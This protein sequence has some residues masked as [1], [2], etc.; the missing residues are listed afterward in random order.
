M[1]QTSRRE[2]K[3]LIALESP[4]L[5]ASC[6]GSLREHLITATS[7]YAGI[8]TVLTGLAQAF[9]LKAVPALYNERWGSRASGITLIARSIHDVDYHPSTRC[10]VTHV[11]CL[12]RPDEEL[13]RTFGVVN[14][15]PDGLDT[16]AFNED[17]DLP[18]LA[19]ATDP[20][21]VGRELRAEGLLATSPI[22]RVVPVRYRA[23]SRCLLRLDTAAGSVYLKVLASDGERIALMAD[24]LRGVPPLLQP[25]GYSSKLH[26][27]VLP[28]LPGSAELHRLAFD[29][30]LPAAARL[31][32]MRDSGAALATLHAA[33]STSGPPR[34]IVD[35]AHD[36]DASAAPLAHA[37]PALLPRFLEGVRRLLDIR[38]EEGPFVASHGGFRTD[39][40]LLVRDEPMIIDLDG[41][42][43]ANPARDL[44]NF[45]A[46]LR[47]KAIRE[48]QHAGFI[49]AAIPSFLEGYE[50]VREV[51]AQTWMARYE[52]A[53]L[54]KIASRRFRKLS[55]S[56]W[57]LVPRL[58]D[59]ADALLRL[60][61]RVVV[62]RAAA[63][64]LPGC[65]REA[66]DVAG[67][68][69]RLRPLLDRPG[70]NRRPDVIRAELVCEKPGERWTIRY[71]LA[72]GVPE[73]MGK[74]FK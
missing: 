48:P 34:G 66:L 49:G 14:V 19:H 38:P 32:W 44:G 18:W 33:R 54:L 12:E 53:S 24:A 21:E 42:C 64:E 47:W 52:A 30:S 28:E 36:L 25:L 10:R 40:L 57:P 16:W 20:G 8:D 41:L 7:R 45:L 63:P 65:V 27:L 43:W 58:L 5:D 17:P 37:A 69:A 71:T 35:D 50:T 51:P 31:R 26:A 39:Q 13:S 46:H 68:T 70:P 15:R 60:S 6:A 61:D 72:G 62:A 67:M 3:A 2:P 23:G 55:V 1:S 29:A 59:E 74:M 56:E 73:V 9:D 22:A 4:P 11:L